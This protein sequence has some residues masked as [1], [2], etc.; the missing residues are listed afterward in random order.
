MKSSLRKKVTLDDIQFYLACGAI[1]TPDLYD[2]FL[3]DLS[4]LESNDK[5]CLVPITIF[6]RFHN[7]LRR[8]A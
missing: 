7:K 3:K 4:I 6:Q 8:S 1:P 5:L 2:V